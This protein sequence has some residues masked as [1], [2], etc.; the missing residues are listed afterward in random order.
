MSGNLLKY[1]VLC[2]VLVY[3][4]YARPC[5]VGA[6]SAAEYEIVLRKIMGCYDTPVAERTCVDNRALRKFYRWIKDE[7]HISVGPSGKTIYID[8]K[9]LL[10]KD[11]I[12]LAIKKAEKDTKCS[13]ARKLAERI[14]A[15]FMGCSENIV[16]DS[17]SRRVNLKV[18]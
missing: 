1:L 17:K 6:L 11:E 7:R 4:T 12:D 13:G 9:K 16:V 18:R 5:N 3:V 15:R 10:K 2:T 8:G 14:K